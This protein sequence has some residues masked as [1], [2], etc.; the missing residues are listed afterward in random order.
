MSDYLE[1]QF[2]TLKA[3]KDVSSTSSISSSKLF[4]V[5]V[6]MRHGAYL[7]SSETAESTEN[8]LFKVETDSD[9]DS[10]DKAS[11]KIT[12]Q[13]AGLDMFASED[14]GCELDDNGRIVDDQA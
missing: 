4:K 13:L 3:I 14:D 8:E 9:D 12:F 11:H 6:E 10:E 2:K 5:L 1:N 7:V